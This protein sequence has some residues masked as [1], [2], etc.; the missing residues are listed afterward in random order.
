MCALTYTPYIYMNMHTYT[1]T[2][3][4]TRMDAYLILQLLLQALD[5]VS[6]LNVEHEPADV[7]ESAP[8]QPRPRI[9]LKDH[10]L[11]LLQQL[12]KE[13][14]EMSARPPVSLCRVLHHWESQ[15]W[16]TRTV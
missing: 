12:D 15:P 11:V 7:L 5:P 1:H 8:G 6:Q 14:C 13:L 9:L 3:A 2:H 4:L 16:S 10:C